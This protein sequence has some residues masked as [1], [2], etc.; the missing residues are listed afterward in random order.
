MSLH[1]AILH[2]VDGGQTWDM[3]PHPDI[4]INQANRI[5]AVAPDNIWIADPMGGDTGMVHSGDGGQTWQKE[6]FPDVISGH[7]PIGVSAVSASVVWSAISQQGDF[8]RTLD[9]GSNW[10][11]AAPKLAGPFDF[12]DMCAI[13]ADLVWAVLN[14]SGNSGGVIFRVRIEN[15]K[16]VKDE[17]QPYVKYQYEGITAF[18]DQKACVVGYR[19]Y[20]ADPK[21]PA[22][23]IL[24]TQDGGAN[25]TSQKLPTDDVRLWKVSFVGAHR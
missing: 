24:L 5:D 9:G 20:D 11:I 14:Y 12:D 8:Y 19:V 18:D 3:V 2:T 22:G 7:G 15:S 21:L 10:T 6:Y 1:G 23:T 13:D 4:Q 16:V 17:W 25:W